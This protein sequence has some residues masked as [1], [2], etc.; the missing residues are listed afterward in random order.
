MV[1]R[2]ELIG[3]FPSVLAAL[4]DLAFKNSNAPIRLRGLAES[5]YT[6]TNGAEW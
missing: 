2:S 5:E 4:G 1:G 6:G 3:R